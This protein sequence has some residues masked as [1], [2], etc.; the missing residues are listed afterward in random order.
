MICS[1]LALL[2]PV[3]NNN[4]E[5]IIESNSFCREFHF[6]GEMLYNWMVCYT[7]F[8]SF[9]D[10]RSLNAIWVK[11]LF[12]NSF[13]WLY[14]IR[15]ILYGL[16]AWHSKHLSDLFSLPGQSWSLQLTSWFSLPSQ[17]TSPT[18]PLIQVLVWVLLPPPQVT[19]HSASAQLLQT[20][21]VC[22]L[23]SG[24]HYRSIWF[25]F[26]FAKDCIVSEMRVKTQD[27]VWVMQ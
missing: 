1:F 20:E 21:I 26:W 9:K 4:G 25:R 24:G 23:I 27:E 15:S 13:S 17:P 18:L 11:C 12:D 6:D 7:P 14:A 2:W 22:F 5:S 19:E 8:D 16:N 10:N 3:S